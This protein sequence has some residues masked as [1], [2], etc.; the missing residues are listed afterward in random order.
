MLRHFPTFDSAAH[1]WRLL[2]RDASCPPQYVLAFLAEVFPPE[3]VLVEVHRTVGEF[4]PLGAAAEFIAPHVGKAH[5]RIANR[6]F[7]TL[8]VIASPGVATSWRHS[9]IQ[10]SNAL[11]TGRLQL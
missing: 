4:L 9:G 2:M 10:P 7:T 3:P 8:A 6:S 5:T 11:A 1:D